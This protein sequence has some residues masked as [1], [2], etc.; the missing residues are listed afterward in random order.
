MTSSA[1]QYIAI[2]AAC[3]AVP[4]MSFC[5]LYTGA[6]RCLDAFVVALSQA[7]GGD[8]RW[9]ASTLQLQLVSLEFSRACRSIPKLAVSV[10]DLTPR[11]LWTPRDSRAPPNTPIS[12]A[13][14]SS[15]LPI[16]RALRLT[17]ALPLEVL[18]ES[19][20]VELWAWSRFVHL[21]GPVS[22]ARLASVSWPQ[23]LVHLSFGDDFNQSIVGV[24]WPASL[25]QLSFGYVFNQPIVGVVW[26]VRLKWL[27]WGHRFNQPI[28]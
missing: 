21:R 10:E 6:A 25:Q 24:V 19:A 3:V 23:A 1:S 8:R 12:E 13:R 5:R 26:P 15:R 2:W 16:Q 14:A 7:C 11:S 28:A 20:A 22:S 27:T 4:A 17:W 18:V 9:Y